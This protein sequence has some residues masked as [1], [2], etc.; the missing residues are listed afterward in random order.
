M[1]IHLSLLHIASFVVALTYP[2][3][4]AQKTASFKAV[5]TAVHSVNMLKLFEI[6]Q[7]LNRRY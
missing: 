6:E 2:N 5:Q 4:Q 1:H 7:K 3:N